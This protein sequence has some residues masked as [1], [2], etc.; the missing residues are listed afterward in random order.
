M[1]QTNRNQYPILKDWRET[2]LEA[3]S[4]FT[5]AGASL[6]NPIIQ[7]VRYVIF[8][9]IGRMNYQWEDNP[10]ETSFPHFRFY[11]PPIHK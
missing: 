4:L 7:R 10:D 11:K 8:H 5:Y 9:E 2:V 1:P 3:G 6:A